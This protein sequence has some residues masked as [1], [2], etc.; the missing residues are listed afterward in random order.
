[1]DSGYASIE[2]RGAGDDGPPS[3][4]E[5]R[6]SFTSAG[7]VAT[8]GSSFEVARPPPPRRPRRRPPAPQPARLARRAP[9]RDYSIDEKTDALFHEFLRHDPHFDDA[10]PPPR[11]TAH[12]RIRTRANS[13]RSAAGST[14]TLGAR[15]DHRPARRRP[16]AHAR[17]PAPRRQRRLPARRPR[18]RPPPLPPRRP[19]HPRHRGGAWRRLPR[20]RPVRHAPDALLDKLAAGLEDRLFPPRLVQPVA[21]VPAL[22]AAAPTSP[23]HSPA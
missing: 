16:P 6:S 17:A 4:S 15:R 12:A 13:G 5:K 14:A 2:G 9:R 18:G 7:R 8:V 23:D 19:R 10:P 11:A 1:M 3:A 21:A 20:L 22:A